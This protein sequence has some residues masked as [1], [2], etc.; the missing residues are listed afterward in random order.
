ME[1]GFGPCER[2]KIRGD[3]E[4]LTMQGANAGS[5]DVLKVDSTL[6]QRCGFG[7]IEVS[8]KYRESAK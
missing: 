4:A 1:Y 5:K 8:A 2:R 7:R 3:L 6:R